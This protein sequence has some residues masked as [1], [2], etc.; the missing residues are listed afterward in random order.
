MGCFWGPSESIRNTNGVLSTVVGYAGGLLGSS[1]KPRQPPTY[2]DVCYGDAWVEAVMVVY[3]DKIVSY[4]ALLDSF[5]EV[6]KPREGERQYQSLVFPTDEVQFEIAQSWL[7]SAKNDGRKRASDGLLVSVVDIEYNN[8]NDGVLFYQAEE[9]HQEFWKKWRFRIAVAVFLVTTSFDLSFV[10][11]SVE[12][13]SQWNT[14]IS[15][16][17]G[18]G[19]FY[20]LVLERI[21]DDRV[22]ELRPGAFAVSA[23]EA[24]NQ[25]RNKRL[26]SR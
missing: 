8:N 5:W 25:R 14:D 9:Y 19:A 13:Q 2:D 18:L 7:K 17:L 16:I 22:R 4:D 1:L 15:I 6:Q 21:I 11:V 10:N 24:R 3:D 23:F 26:R 12:A 20:Y